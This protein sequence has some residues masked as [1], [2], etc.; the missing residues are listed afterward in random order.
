MSSVLTHEQG[1]RA[2]AAHPARRE[3]DSDLWVRYRHHGD[4][5]ARET[6]VERFMPLARQVARRYQRPNEPIDDLLQVANLGLVNAVDRYDPSR[7]TAFSTYAVPTILGELKRYFRDT[8][9]AAHVPR[10]MQERAMTL[11]RAAD[12]LRSRLG[13]SPTAPE[14][15]DELNLT[16]E[17]LF[18]AME[19]ASA[20]RSASLDEEYDDGDSREPG[21]A[22]SL[23]IQDER[24]DLVEYGAMIAPALRRLG[25]RERLILRLRFLEDLNQWEIADRIGVSQMHVSRLLRRLLEELRTVTAG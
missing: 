14:L 8:T 18:Q 20:L 9:W 4:S 16:S 1:P 22:A 25:D 13:R 3:S 11:D 15:A 12:N 23:G 5:A 24:F 6:L 21:H 10:E 7:G 17:E 19:A 2:A